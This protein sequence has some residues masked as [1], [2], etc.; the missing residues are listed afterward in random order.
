MSSSSVISIS[1][2]FSSPVC[3]SN[4]T[5]STS[6]CATFV[7][8]LPISFFCSTF[9]AFMKLPKDTLTCSSW[10]SFESCSLSFLCLSYV[11]ASTDSSICPSYE[12]CMKLPK[13]SLTSSFLY[14][15]ESSSSSEGVSTYSRRF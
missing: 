14:S 9:D 1:I 7:T 5:M 2:F 15:L 11:I 6:S 10:F 12:V 13:D 4:I 3:P 8:M